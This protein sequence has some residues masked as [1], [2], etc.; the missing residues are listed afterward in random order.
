VIFIVVKLPVRPDQSDE[1][2]SL[3]EDFTTATRAEPGNL[4]FEWSRSV[5][6][7]D[8]FVLV[9]AF[10]DND[11]GAAHVNSDHF[12]KAMAWMPDSV[13]ATPDIINVE[14]AGGGW[15]KMAEVQPRQA[16]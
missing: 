13:A 6:N 8:Q 9:E 12:K 2:M 10:R 16:E 11:A 5:D 7:P 14:V 15:S 4:F 1:W 3:V